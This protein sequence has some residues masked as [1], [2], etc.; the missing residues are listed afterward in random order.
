MVEKIPLDLDRFRARY[1]EICDEIATISEPSSKS[2]ASDP[3]PR[4]VVVSKYLD[5]SDARALIDAGISP[6]GENRAPELE[7]K[8]RPEDG[9]AWHFIGHL[10]RNKI[11]KVISRVGCVHS[12]DSARLAEAIDSA[13]EEADQTLSGLVQINV[14]GETSKGGLTPDQALDQ[15]PDWARRFSHLRLH[16]LMTMA[17]LSDPEEARPVFR[18]LRELRDRLRDRLQAPDEFRELSMGMSNDYRIACEEGATLLR[19]GSTL[20]R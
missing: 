20:Y 14:S 6:L 4:I 10:Q 8:Q 15:I 18:A 2:M 1:A 11:A 17:P 12:I 16:G 13:L 5:T 9:P 19:V 3:A 7:A